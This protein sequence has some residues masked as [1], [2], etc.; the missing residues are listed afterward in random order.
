MATLRIPYPVSSNV[1]WR[2]RVVGKIAMV[3]V[4]PEAKAYKQQVGWIA[5]AAGIKKIVGAVSVKYVL[6][7]KMV[8]S[9]AASK[10]RLDLDNCIKVCQDALNGI[11]YADDDQIYEIYA[12]IG[13]PVP[14]G[15]IDVTISEFK[16]VDLFK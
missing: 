13:N 9:G 6:H 3:Y 15:A 16:P 14:D 1:Y 7:P 8:K 4:S 5:K 2:H 10:V 11:A 12:S